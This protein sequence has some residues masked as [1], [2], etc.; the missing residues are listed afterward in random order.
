MA[1]RNANTDSPSATVG[2]TRRND[3]P[4]AASE[5]GGPLNGESKSEVRCCQ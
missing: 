3:D 5:F 4:V 1:E 2:D